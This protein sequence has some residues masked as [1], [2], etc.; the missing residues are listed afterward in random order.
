LRTRTPFLL[1]AVV[2]ATLISLVVAGSALAATTTLSANLKGGAAETPTGD[3]NGSG[4]VSITID[5]ATRQVC[6]NIKVANIAP[7]TASHIHVGAAGVSGGVVVPLNVT[8]FTG[9]TTGCAAAPA[10]ADLAAIIANPADFYVNVH[11]ADFPAGA[12]RGQ[13]ALATPNTA[14]KSPEG[15]PLVPLGLALVLVGMADAVRKARGRV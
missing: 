7:A 12:V 3:P 10:A 14:F 2:T 11:T 8:G 5:P 9:S 4:T 15:S 1:M 6:W 13:L